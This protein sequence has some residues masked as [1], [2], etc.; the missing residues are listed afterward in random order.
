VL[1]FEREDELPGRKGPPGFAEAISICRLKPHMLE[2]IRTKETPLRQATKKIEN[3]PPY[4]PD[5]GILNTLRSKKETSAD[6]DTT[7]LGKNRR[8]VNPPKTG[9]VLLRDSSH[10]PGVTRGTSNGGRS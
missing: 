1:L 5:M 2:T 3:R 4:L 10:N 6:T 9:Q 7:K 8:I